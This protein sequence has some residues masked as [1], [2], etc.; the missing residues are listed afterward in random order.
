ML[1]SAPKSN[2]RPE[3]RDLLPPQELYIDNIL[4][5]TFSKFKTYQKGERHTNNKTYD[6]SF[7]PCGPAQCGCIRN[8]RGNQSISQTD[9]NSMQPTNI[10]KGRGFKF[11]NNIILHNFTS[12]FSII[13]N[14]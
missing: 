8:L 4:N 2:T 9:F 14:Q 13:I 5:L 1:S 7:D 11:L 3:L 10:L 12:F 6:K